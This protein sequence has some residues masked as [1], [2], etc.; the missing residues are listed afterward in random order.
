MLTALK[1]SF[2]GMF[3]LHE[4]TATLNAM[5]EGVSKSLETLSEIGGKVQEEAVKAGYG[6]TIRADAVKKLVE[7][8]VDYQERAQQIIDEMRKLAT[9][10]SAEIRDAVEDGKRRIAKLV[11]D[12]KALPL[13]MI[14]SESTPE[15]AAGKPAQRLA[16]RSTNSCS[17][18]TWSTRCAI[19]SGWSSAS[20][21]RTCA[22]S[23]SIERLRELYK[24]QGIEV[25][26]SIIAEGVKALKESRFVYTPPLPSF[27]R[28]LATFWVSARTYGK[29]A[30][31]AAVALVASFSGPINTASCAARSRRPR[32]HA[33]E[34]AQT[35]P[36]QLDAAHQAIVAEAQVARRAAACGCDPGAGHAPRS[37]AATR[38]K[39][40][41]VVAPTRSLASRCGRNTCSGSPGG[42]R[43]RPASSASIRASRAAPISSWSTPSIRAASRYGFPIRND[44]TNQTETVSR[45]AVRVPI[46]TFNAVRNDKA[47]ERHRAERRVGREA[48][49]LSSSPSS[50]CRRSQA[51]S[52]AGRG[53]RDVHRP[54]CAVLG[55]AGDQ[56]GAR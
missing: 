16:P 22:R 9:Q 26:D 11:A 32:R 3:G 19:A 27:A 10:N 8:V 38:R 18:W 49:R 15:P 47:S 23:S 21:T 46:E 7:S 12:G 53:R 35:L 4:S 44:E 20:S 52:P 54:R 24:S 34:L 40:A 41:Q 5:K 1:A 37:S 2:T 30:V 33:I 36:R 45:F 50:G 25:P 55:R 43:T 13:C 51:A 6:P 28:T 14:A 31:G 17:R 29:W 56:P 48:P 42:P 39:R